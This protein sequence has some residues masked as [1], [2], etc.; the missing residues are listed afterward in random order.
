[1]ERIAQD[2]SYLRF[3]AVSVSSGTALEF[4]FDSLINIAD[5]KLG[6]ALAPFMIA[7]MIS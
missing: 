3:H 7:I 2:V 1:M 6:H 5:N 4:R